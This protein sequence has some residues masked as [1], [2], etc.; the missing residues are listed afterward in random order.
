MKEMPGFQTIGFSWSLPGLLLEQS[1]PSYPID[2]ALILLFP[3]R[4]TA[5]LEMDQAEE[6]RTLVRKCGIMIQKSTGRWWRYQ[7]HL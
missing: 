2:F 5:K 3:D 6:H 4:P 1:L 7:L